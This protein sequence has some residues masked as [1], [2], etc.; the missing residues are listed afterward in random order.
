M[1]KRDA[2]VQKLHTKIDEWNREIDRLSSKANEVEADARSEYR[3][4]V[5]ALKQKRRDIEEKIKHLNRSGEEA[6]EDIKSG[7]D[8]AWDAMNQ[9]IQ[10]AT[11]RFR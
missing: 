9:A 1:E 3:K 5:D 6:W 2:Y 7:L 8:M 11:S 10:S 4:Q